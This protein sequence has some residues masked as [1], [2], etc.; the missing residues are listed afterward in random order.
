MS[1]MSFEE[2]SRPAV[3]S[4]DPRFSVLFGEAPVVP[5]K[6][7]P[8]PVAEAYERGLRE[9]AAAAAV[10]AERL[11]HEREAARQKIEL[12]F[13]LFDQ[14]SATDLAERLRQTVHALCEAAVIPLA[15]DPDGLAK[16]TEK[17]VS[18]LQ[19]AQDE[20]LVLLN[21]EDFDLVRQRL[22]KDFKVQADPSVERGG[23]RIETA[24]GG[25][26]DGPA[27]WRRMLTEAFREC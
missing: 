22:P 18:M 16:R 14:R 7:P 9:G 6:A 24:D 20:K 17:A 23:L 12:A 13:A 3:F 25:I 1:S 10:E 11:D 26:E 4:R 15:I 27:H 2:F 5:G 21:P 8:D 19:R